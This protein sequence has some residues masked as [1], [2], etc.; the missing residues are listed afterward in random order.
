[1]KNQNEKHADHYQQLVEGMPVGLIVEQ[2]PI[3]MAIVGMD[4]TIEFINRKAVQVFGYLH[5]DI[6]TMDRWWVQAYPEEVYRKEVVADWTGRIQKALTEGREIAGNEYRVTCKDGAVKTMFISGVPVSDKIFVMFDDI[7]ER[8]RAENLLA[9]QRTLALA[10]NTTTSIEMWLE[11]CLEAALDA[12]GMD[13]GGIYLVSETDSSLKLTVHKGLSPTFIASTSFFDAQSPNSRLV[14]TG[15][16]VYSEY[17]NLDILLDDNQRKEMLRAIAVIPVTYENRVIG[18]FNIASH[19]RSD[20]PIFARSALETIAAQIGTGIARLKT[21]ESLRESEER[22]SKAFKTSPYA[23]II[24]NME[25]GAIIEVNDAFTTMSGF[26]REEAL[27]GSTLTLKIWVNEE[28]RQRMVAA[29]REGRAV[30]GLETS[31][32][33]KNGNIKTVLLSAKVLRLGHKSC[34]LSIVEDITERKRAEEELRDS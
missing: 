33:G 5:E 21:Q 14:M 17:T 1:M 28:D 12:S 13:S 19:T 11:L 15:Q 16:P 23:Y 32:R 26:T 3:A 8:K 25:D 34:I 20:V 24:A 27:A 9:I 6:P 18:C 4:G 31:L 7:T 29:L 2:A 10:L 30:V 22:F